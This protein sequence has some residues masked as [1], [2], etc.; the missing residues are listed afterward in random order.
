MRK[1]LVVNDIAD[2]GVVESGYYNDQNILTAHAT[3][4]SV[5]F[6]EELRQYDFVKVAFGGSAYTDIRIFDTA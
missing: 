3:A 5:T 2:K 1:Q 6:M 4:L